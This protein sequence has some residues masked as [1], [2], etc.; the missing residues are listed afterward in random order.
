MEVAAFIVGNVQRQKVAWDGQGAQR[1]KSCLG[2]ILVIMLLGAPCICS[3]LQDVNVLLTSSFLNLSKASAVACKLLLGWFTAHVLPVPLGTLRTFISPILP[4]F[5]RAPRSIAPPQLPAAKLSKLSFA[6]PAAS[7]HAVK[8]KAAKNAS[9]RS[10]RNNYSCAWWMQHYLLRVQG[11][12]AKE[13]HSPVLKVALAACNRNRISLLNQE[14]RSP[15][16]RNKPTEQNLRP[17]LKA[18]K[19]PVKV[20]LEKISPNSA[21]LGEI[22]TQP[23]E[24]QRKPIRRNRSTSWAFPPSRWGACACERAEEE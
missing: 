2:A 17:T 21:L 23:R 15:L 24:R 3:K 12:C 6:R 7:F 8:D 20:P 5:V 10:W 9:F 14:A 16:S 22:L 18:N 4:G 13:A 11:P 19:Q 1:A